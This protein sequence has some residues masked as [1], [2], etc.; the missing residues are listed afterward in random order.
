MHTHL[1]TLMY[2]HMCIPPTLMKTHTHVCGRLNVC[3]VRLYVRI[4]VALNVYIYVISTYVCTYIPT[5]M[6]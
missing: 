5:C 3:A 6:F 2:E 1:Q 4:S